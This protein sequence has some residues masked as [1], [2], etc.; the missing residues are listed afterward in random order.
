MAVHDTTPGPNAWLGAVS[1]NSTPACRA[2]GEPHA[3]RT[4]WLGS[5]CTR[6]PTA[7]GGAARGAP[8][9]GW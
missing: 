6:M 7:A 4:K 3:S 1:S 8:G 5:C 9:S 2:S